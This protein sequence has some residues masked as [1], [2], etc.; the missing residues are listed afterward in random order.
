MK[1]LYL[2]VFA[3]HVTTGVL[4]S[5]VLPA[6]EALETIPIK[7]PH[8][9]NC[10]D[11]SFNMC[12]HNFNHYLSIT[13]EADFNNVDTLVQEIRNLLKLGV[14]GGLL[15]LCQARSLFY[16]CLGT[17]YTSCMSRFHFLGHGQNLTAATAFVQVFN[18]LEFMCNGGLLQSIQKWDCIMQNAATTQ[19]SLDK[20]RQDFLN[21][22]QYNPSSICDAAEKM[23]LC[24]RE[25]YY[26]LCGREVA[27]WSCEQARIALNIDQYCTHMTCSYD[28]YQPNTLS[29]NEPV[30]R[31]RRDLF[32]SLNPQ[33]MSPEKMNLFIQLGAKAAEREKRR[34]REGREEDE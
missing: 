31:T 27:W 4:F 10:D 23:M 25:P 13:S 5:P 14:E 22:T 3:F 24:W 28:I 32:H 12:Q 20:C 33:F 34:K 29:G 26:S 30:L 16:Q 6:L 21:Q 15:R 8:P 1:P 9:E 18:E 11:I 2:L 7:V 17:R 19:N